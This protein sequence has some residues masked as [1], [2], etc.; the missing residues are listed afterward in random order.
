MAA[1][2]S[3]HCILCGTGSVD[4]NLDTPWICFYGARDHFKITVITRE[5]RNMLT[6]IYA[7]EQYL[8]LHTHC[9][10][11]SSVQ[12]L[13]CE[14]FS[15]YHVKKFLVFLWNLE[16]GI[17]EETIMGTLL[18]CDAGI[19]FHIVSLRSFNPSMPYTVPDTRG[20]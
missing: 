1:V 6:D 20:I 14:V 12:N 2:C 3:I 7:P 4:Y 18:S 15:H 10:S 17:S 5:C 16:S 9:L 13:S 11:N 8:N 19:Q